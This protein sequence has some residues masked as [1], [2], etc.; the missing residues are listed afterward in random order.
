MTLLQHQHRVV[1]GLRARARSRAGGTRRAPA[2]S[3]VHQRSCASS[4]RPA[5]AVREARVGEALDG[6]CMDSTGTAIAARA[7]ELRESRRDRCCRRRRR[8]RRCGGRA[9]RSRGDSAAATAQRGGAFGDHVAAL[10]DE[11]HRRAPR[12]RARRRS[13]R[14]TYSRSSGHIVSSTDLPPAP[15]TNERLPFV[16]A[17]GRAGRQRRCER[18]R[19]L[20]LGGVDAAPRAAARA[21]RRRC[22]ASSPPPPIGATTASTSGRSSTNLEPRRAVAADEIVVVERMDEVAG[23]RGRTGA[24][25]RSASTRRTSALTIVAPSRSMA[26]SLVCRRACPSPSRCS[27]APALRAASATPCAALPALTVQTPSAQLRRASAGGRR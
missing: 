5:R 26:R 15:S 18:R 22:P 12:R 7:D 2:G 11:P 17:A 16:E 27:G 24:S 1:R 6:R 3:S 25:R 14:R 20:R 13:S 4:G 9:P 8:R 23:H 10:G 21:A 19:G